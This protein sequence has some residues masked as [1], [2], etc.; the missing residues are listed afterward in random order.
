[1]QSP[2]QN[3]DTEIPL[4]VLYPQLDDNRTMITVTSVDTSTPQDSAEYMARSAMDVAE[5]ATMGSFVNPNL[6]P[7][8]NPIG[9]GCPALTGPITEDAEV[10]SDTANTNLAPG[11]DPNRGA[12]LEGG[13]RSPPS[14]YHH[15]TGICGRRAPGPMQQ[16]PGS[17][18]SLHFPPR[19]LLCTTAPQ[20]IH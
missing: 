8:V 3:S 13:L 19:R 11:L 15:A 4:P 20:S 14:I 1:M 17:R 16:G 9:V 2:S 7:Q 12:T 18:I 6:G 5:K 10:T